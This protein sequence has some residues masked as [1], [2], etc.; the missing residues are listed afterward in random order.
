MNKMDK[1]LQLKKI[2]FDERKNIQ[3]IIIMIIIIIIN[4]NYNKNWNF[5]CFDFKKG[6][7]ILQILLTLW[8]IGKRTL[9]RPVQSVIILVIK[10]I[11]FVN[12]SYDYRPN[13]TPLIPV[14]ITNN[15]EYI[16]LIYEILDANLH[17]GSK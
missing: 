7:Y 15:T 10:Q 2:Y 12:H 17:T 3:I 5:F 6:S 9:C 8:L 13:W 11:D 4:H 14:T 1:I 16:I